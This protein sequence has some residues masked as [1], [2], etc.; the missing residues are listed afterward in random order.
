MRRSSNLARALVSGCTLVIVAGCGLFVGDAPVL[1][2]VGTDPSTCPSGTACDP[3]THFCIRTQEAS[4][5]VVE[6]GDEKMIVVE[7]STDAPKE[8]E[9]GGPA[10]LG[11]KCRVDNDCKSHLCASST[12]LT[13]TIAPTSS[14]PICTMP[15]CISTECPA[16]FVC[17][18]GGTGGG[19]CVSATVA[20]RTPPAIGGK[21]G[22]SACTGNTDCR[23]GL[24]T[25]SPLKCLDTCCMESDCN[26]TSTCRIATV[27]APGPTHDIWVCAPADPG[28]TGLPG[29]A[30]T[31]ST[32]CASDACIGISSGRIC[33]PSC[34]NTASCTGVLGF[35]SGHCAYGTSGTD[36]F[37]FCLPTTN[38]ARSAAGVAC[39]DDSLCQ[40]DY[41]DPELAKC[42]NV[43]ARDSDCG[44]SEACRPSATGTPFLRCVPKP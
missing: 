14:G 24:C 16:S 20:E 35:S 40:S 37:K 32:E 17:F 3:V 21:L 41:C 8:A 43:C 29:D 42:A 25:G 6:A 13:P 44:A 4:V 23:S 33:H 39:S 22:G 27:S 5:P 7:A 26:G 15:C 1:Q 34:S 11:A 2:C 36:H 30:C 38:L 28:A 9:A 18:N 12:I 19:Y 10:D 31:D